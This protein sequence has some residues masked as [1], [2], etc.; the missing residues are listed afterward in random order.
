MY[1]QI[2]VKQMRIV[3]IWHVLATEEIW[4][5][6][7]VFKFAF[8]MSCSIKLYNLMWFLSSS[9]TISHVLTLI[10]DSCV[11]TYKD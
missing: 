1:A 6:L 2:N 5:T 10:S 9:E 3:A 4:Y 8:I 7:Y 11:F